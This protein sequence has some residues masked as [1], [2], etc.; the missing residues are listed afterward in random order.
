VLRSSTKEM[1]L[2]HIN[3]SHFHH[4]MAKDALILLQLNRKSPP[5]DIGDLNVIILISLGL[6]VFISAKHV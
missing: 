5:S 4:D 3:G 2:S 6:L 1:S